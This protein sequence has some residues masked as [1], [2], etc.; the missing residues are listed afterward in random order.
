MEIIFDSADIL[1]NLL[2]EKKSSSEITTEEMNQLSQFMEE[3]MKVSATISN[4]IID[5]LELF[6]HT[7]YKYEELAKNVDSYELEIEDLKKQLENGKNNIDYDK[8]DEIE[9]DSQKV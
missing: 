3:T 9:R 2:N 1:K 7:S 6:A 4:E 8:L 5:E